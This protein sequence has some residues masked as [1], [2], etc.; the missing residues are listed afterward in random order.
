MYLNPDR[1]Y[2]TL[3]AASAG[4]KYF[5]HL[6]LCMSLDVESA[7]VHGSGRALS[8]D[9]GAVF[10]PCEWSHSVA[11]DGDKLLS[12]PAA[13]ASGSRSVHNPA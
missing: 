7:D 8:K 9:F 4:P 5:D 13:C 3:W 11:A 6:E 1:Y 10:L 12:E 2:L